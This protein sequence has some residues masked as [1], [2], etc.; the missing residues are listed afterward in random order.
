MLTLEQLTKIIPHCGKARRAEFLA[1]LNNAML[2]FEINTP[3]REAAFI[4]QVAH[5][6]GSFVYTKE[7]ANGSAYDGRKDLGNTIPEAIS[8]AKAN[9][10]SAGRF[11]KGH[12]LIQLTGYSNHKACGEALGL[13]LIHKPGLITVNPDCCRSA[14]WFWK[15]HGLN[16]LA[17]AGNFDKITRVINGG[18]NGQ[19][20]R[21]AFYRTACLVLNAKVTH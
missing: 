21:R 14:A 17:D 3:L 15:E 19:E 6:S 20:E 13:D 10:M 1:P 8:V 2:E 18:T 9:G 5:E 7:L 16:E 12:G 11:Y 4:A